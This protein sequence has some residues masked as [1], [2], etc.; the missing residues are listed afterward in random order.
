MECD[1]QRGGAASLT[2]RREDPGVTWFD[3]ADDPETAAA[4]EE[5]G[6]AEEWDAPTCAAKLQTDAFV[7]AQVYPRAAQFHAA[8]VTKALLDASGAALVAPLRV[9]RIAP[10]AGDKACLLYT[11]PSPRDS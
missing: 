1:L 2:Q 6:E 9:L 8:K 11:S 5:W 4:E 3:T 10:A 7:D